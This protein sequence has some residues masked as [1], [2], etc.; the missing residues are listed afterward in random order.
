VGCSQY[1][2]RQH[3]IVV[4]SNK[5]AAYNSYV[6]R[7][8]ERYQQGQFPFPV[9]PFRGSYLEMMLALE[10]YGNGECSIALSLK[11]FENKYNG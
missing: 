8:V 1:E 6:D 5:D 2:L 7:L 11:K 9:I 3:G 4:W 10:P